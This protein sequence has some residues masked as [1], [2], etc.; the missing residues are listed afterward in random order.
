M[1]RS[2]SE[3]EKNPIKN[4]NQITNVRQK[5]TDRVNNLRTDDFSDTPTFKP[6][7][8]AL[9]TID[10]NILSFIK[11]D[12]KPIVYEGGN[13]VNV[14]IIYATPERWAAMRLSGYVRDNKSKLIYPL[15]MVK[16]GAVSQNQ[17]LKIPRFEGYH[18]IVYAQR[19]DRNNRFDDFNVREKMRN[20]KGRYVATVIPNFVKIQYECVVWTSFIEQSNLIIEQ[21]LY[22]NNS[23]WGN[24]DSMRYMVT[25]DSFDNAVDITADSERIVKNTFSFEI[26]AAVLPDNLHNKIPSKIILNPVSISFSEHIVSSEVQ[27]DDITEINLTPYLN[28]YD[29]ND[30]LI[31]KKFDDLLILESEEVVLL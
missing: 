26:S 13:S 20:K 25:I 29:N 19:W 11:N 17:D 4:I 5:L 8:S 24:K 23:Y 7:S 3:V 1:G 21:F 12:I 28:I 30:Y 18:M 31:N 22:H 16:R 9:Y 10:F 15:V 27:L 2:F 14:P 6:Y